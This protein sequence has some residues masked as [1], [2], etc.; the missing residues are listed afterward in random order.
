MGIEP[1]TRR[2]ASFQSLIRYQPAIAI[3]NPSYH[4][5]CSHPIVGSAVVVNIKDSQIVKRSEVCVLELFEYV[6]FQAFAEGQVL[7]P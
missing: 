7:G 6:L 3:R 1:V 2:T 5:W 4:I